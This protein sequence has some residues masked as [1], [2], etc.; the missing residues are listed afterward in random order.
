[1]TRY[2]KTSIPD[3][4]LLLTTGAYVK[5]DKIDQ[6]CGVQLTN[7][8]TMAAQFD[9][10]IDRQVGGVEEIDKPEYDELKKKQSETPSRPI[11]R[12][13][14]GPGA[15]NNA[16]RNRL[17]ASAAEGE[18]PKMETVSVPHPHNNQAPQ[19]IDRPKSIKR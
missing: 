8:P 19:K 3:T 11:W 15:I 10:A 13:E 5:W 16:F 17:S 4:K 12:E 2:F 9:A 18:R 14:L 6:R 1:M 7:D